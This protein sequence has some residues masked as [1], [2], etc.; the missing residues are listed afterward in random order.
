MA[1]L[2]EDIIGTSDLAPFYKVENADEVSID[3]IVLLTGQS[4]AFKEGSG[5]T[6]A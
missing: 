3:V 2:G 6:L 4:A 5:A 1:A